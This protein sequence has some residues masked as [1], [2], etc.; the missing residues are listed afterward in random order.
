MTTLAPAVLTTTIDSPIGPL[1]ITAEGDELTGLH[2]H[3][4]RHFPAIPATAERDDAAL[5]PIVEQLQAYFSG[6]SSAFELKLDLRGTDFQQSVW[7]ALQEI[8]YG[9]TISYGELARWVGNPNASRAVGTANGHNPVA[10]IVPCHRVIAADGGI[11]GYGGGLERKRWLLAHE[12]RSNS[13]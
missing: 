9:E 3:R 12:A 1:T 10:V 7:A 11:G 6:E 5:A 2:M 13:R 8:P 4:Q